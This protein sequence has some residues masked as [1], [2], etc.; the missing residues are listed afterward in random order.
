[1]SLIWKISYC[2]NYL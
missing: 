2:K 1:M